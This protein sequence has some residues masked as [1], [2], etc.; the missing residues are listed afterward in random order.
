M[1]GV[2]VARMPDRA[3]INA[4]YDKARAEGRMKCP[5]E[6]VLWF[7]TVED[8]RIHFN[9]TRIVKHDATDTLSL[10]DAEVEGHRQVMDFVRFLKADVPGFENARLHAI[11]ATVGV[12]ESR[13]VRGRAYLTR[14]DF[15][16]AAKFPDAIARINY[17]IDIHSP[18]GGGTELVRMPEGEWYEVPYGCVVAADCED[19]LVG[20][21]SISVDHAVHSSMRPMAPVCTIGQACGTAAA[22][23]ARQGVAPAEVDGAEVRRSLVEQGVW[24]GEVSQATA[25]Q[26]APL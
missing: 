26:R 1:A 15:E 12:R 11:A 25:A 22:M 23:A 10:S 17:M 4:L 18:T 5:R 24:L 7:R 2:D 14:A 3:A 21:R 9:T 19:L 13:R 20:G 6:D 8:D 16:A